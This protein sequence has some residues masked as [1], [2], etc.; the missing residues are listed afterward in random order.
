MLSARRKS[1]LEVGF[2][3]IISMAPRD[4]DKEAFSVRQT[5]HLTA[6]H[7]LPDSGSLKCD[8]KGSHQQTMHVA[9]AHRKVRMCACVPGPLELMDLKPFFHTELG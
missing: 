1:D 3:I 5:W 2:C 9:I 6:L 4:Y 7:T 8:E